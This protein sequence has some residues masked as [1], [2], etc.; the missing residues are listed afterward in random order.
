[1]AKRR[2]QPEFAIQ[3]AVVEH[4][5]VRARFGVQWTATANGGKRDARTGA[6]LKLSGV[7]AG[8]PDILLW[9]KGAS[10]A[11][12]LKADN[13]RLSE[14]QHEF[15]EGLKNAGVYTCVALGL[16]QALKAL[17]AWNLLQ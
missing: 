5:R 11:L 2:A 3:R 10:F 1:M 4:L 12:E 7:K 6:M 16:D 14:S 9:H 17:K 15:L 13:G 8:V